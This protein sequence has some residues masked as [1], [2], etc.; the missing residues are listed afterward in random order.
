MISIFMLSLSKQIS[1]VMLSLSKH[2]DGER[3]AWGAS[4]TRL[5]KIRSKSDNPW[6]N[7]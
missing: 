2:A 1:I 6:A 4:R 5:P 7:R 3:R